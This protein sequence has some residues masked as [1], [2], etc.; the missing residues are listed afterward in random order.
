M[1]AFDMPATRGREEPGRCAKPGCD[2]P[3]GGWD[4]S[5]LCCACA[6]EAFLFERGRRWERADSRTS[7]DALTHKSR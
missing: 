6:L 5:Q 4:R 7:M 3:V 2:Q 1:R